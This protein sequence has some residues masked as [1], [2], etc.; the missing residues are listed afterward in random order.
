MLQVQN[1]FFWSIS[2]IISNKILLISIR[3]P[4][5]AL[6]AHYEAN[7]PTTRPHAGEDS[8]IKIN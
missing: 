2:V 7:T 4:R 1:C 5:G 3:G 6:Y 8:P